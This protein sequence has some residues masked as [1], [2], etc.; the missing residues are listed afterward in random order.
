MRLCSVVDILHEP[1]MLRGIL[2]RILASV[3]VC[4]LDVQWVLCR[5]DFTVDI[6]HGHCIENDWI[7]SAVEFLVWIETHLLLL[8]NRLTLK[9]LFVP[10][11]RL[12][13][14]DHYA[15]RS[16]I[17]LVFLFAA[18]T[19]LAAMASKRNPMLGPG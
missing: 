7:G 12:A 17:F 2:R 9:V 14:I 19:A 13:T 6:V 16:I 1:I 8:L 15:N 4:V 11:L 10:V 3:Q 18:R 5:I